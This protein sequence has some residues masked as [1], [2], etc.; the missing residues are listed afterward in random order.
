MD[1]RLN[2]TIARHPTVKENAI[3]ESVIVH[4]CG[5]WYVQT[6]AFQNSVIL[7]AVAVEGLASRFK[8]MQSLVAVHGKQFH[9]VVADKTKNNINLRQ[10]KKRD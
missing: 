10:K 9:T 6:E 5:W 8:S 7:K 3:S 4:C 2:N 1:E